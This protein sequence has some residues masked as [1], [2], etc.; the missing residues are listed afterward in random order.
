MA[1]YVP[2]PMR[3][4]PSQIQMPVFDKQ[5]PIQI[6]PKL[7]INLY[8]SFV[9]FGFEKLRERNRRI[10]DFET[11]LKKGCDL[12]Q[13]I[14]TQEADLHKKI[15][16]IENQGKKFLGD[17]SEMCNYINYSK[18]KKEVIKL[19]SLIRE[20]E[21]DIKNIS[22]LVMNLKE[23]KKELKSPA[24]L[25]HEYT[26]LGSIVYPL[27]NPRLG[28]C[29]YDDMAIH[30]IYKDNSRD[31][32]AIDLCPREK[33]DGF[34]YKFEILC[35]DVNM[36]L[37]E[38]TPTKKKIEFVLIVGNTIEEN[39]KNSFEDK[40]RTESNMKIKKSLKDSSS[41]EDVYDNFRDEEDHFLRKLR[42]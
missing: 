9:P 31:S 23:T 36:K 24:S 3:N 29:R 30:R 26:N 10:K 17:I 1:R 16:S 11:E 12:L 41:E 18:F 39:D 4:R 25:L 13:K 22:N 34:L 14:R 19:T 35:R 40:K 21:F 38:K 6:S 8:P 20:H 15:V 2:K 7:T 27:H 42:K 37:T 5:P 32:D 33:F 28:W